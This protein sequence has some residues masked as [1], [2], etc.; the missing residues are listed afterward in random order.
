MVSLMG[1]NQ[2]RSH[3]RRWGC[4]GL[5]RGCPQQ[6]DATDGGDSPVI[7]PGRHRPCHHA[8]LQS[9]RQMA[10]TAGRLKRAI[11]FRVPRADWLVSSLDQT[12][13]GVQT[14][15]TRGLPA[16]RTCQNRWP[17]SP[18]TVDQVR[19][20]R[21]LAFSIPPGRSRAPKRFQNHNGRNFFA[22]IGFGTATGGRPVGH[23]RQDLRAR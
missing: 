2:F 14:T 4:S 18:V 20:D 17:N 5:F 10:R 7:L 9:F 8:L 16:C 3:C 6:A 12:S 19:N 15:R 22:H 23:A 11:L 13:S 21:H 1:L